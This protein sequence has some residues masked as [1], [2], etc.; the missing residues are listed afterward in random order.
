MPTLKWLN[1]DIEIWDFPDLPVGEIQRRIRER[2]GR[3]F[4]VQIF[5]TDLKLITSDVSENNT[6]L[7]I[8]V[9]PERQMTEKEAAKVRNKVEQKLNRDFSKFCDVMKRC[10]AVVAGGAVLG[11]IAE[12]PIEDIDVYI[13]QSNAYE[14]LLVMIN[15]MGMNVNEVVQSNRDLQVSLSRG[16]NLR[17]DVSVI[18]DSTPI[19]S[20]IATFDLS[21]CECWWDGSNLYSNDPDGLRNKEGILKPMYRFKF[22]RQLDPKL[23]RRVAKYTDRGFQIALFDDENQTVKELIDEGKESKEGNESMERNND[24]ELLETLLE[25]S[26]TRY[27]GL[28]QLYFWLK[29]DLSSVSPPGLLID[30]IIQGIQRDFKVREMSNEFENDEHLDYLLEEAYADLQ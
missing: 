4:V 7:Y 30:E 6:V 28:F 15:E 22:F 27:P 11:S 21:F 9:S 19:E 17:I 5:D 16:F 25:A 26:R 10:N 18:D 1:G 24:C 20:V 23:L 8:T 12:F 3:N 13:H 29:V 2:Y 14:F